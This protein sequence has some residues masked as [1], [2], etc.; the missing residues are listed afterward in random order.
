[1]HLYHADF[2]LPFGLCSSPALFN[3]YA[4][5]LQ[6]AMQVNHMEDVLHYLDD[7]FKVCPPDSLVCANNIDIMVVICKE[8][9]F[10]ISSKKVTQPS[11]MPNFLG[12][13][14]NS[15]KQQ[16]H[17]DPVQLKDTIANLEGM[18][19]ARSATKYTILSLGGTSI[20][21]LCLHVR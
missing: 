13:D 20:C 21:L 10:A 16:K 15:M 2:F 1:M 4:I 11:T 6:Y 5:A 19:K 7:Y 12:I 17:L 18:S 9:G 3:K 14:I 8:V